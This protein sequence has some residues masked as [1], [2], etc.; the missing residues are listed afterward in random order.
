MV[1]AGGG[2]RG[3]GDGATSQPEGTWRSHLQ[4]EPGQRGQWCLRPSSSVQDQGLGAAPAWSPTRGFPGAGGEG[5]RD[6]SVKEGGDTGCPDGAGRDP[7]QGQEHGCGVPLFLLPTINVGL[8]STETESLESSMLRG[9][10]SPWDLFL[11][12]LG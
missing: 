11:D 2:T 9:L 4:G 5:G 6:P 3:E 7:G 8:M 12:F 10:S 1:R